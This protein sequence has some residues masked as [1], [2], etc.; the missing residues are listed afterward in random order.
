MANTPKSILTAVLL[1]AFLQTTCAQQLPVKILFV[2]NSITSFNNMPNIF[3]Q[4]A[5][6]K[7]HTVSIHTLVF[8]GMRLNNYLGEVQVGET[9]FVSVLDTIATGN[10]NFVIIQDGLLEPVK[11]FEKIELFYN[12]VLKFDSICK[13]H[14]SRLI[15]F[16][17]YPI[18][19]FPKIY[20]GRSLVSNEMGCTE[21]F[22]DE[23][24]L[25][26]SIKDIFNQFNELNII[27]APIGEAFVTARAKHRR[28]RLYADDED[29]H[30]SAFGSYLMACVY[31]RIC[32]SEKLESKTCLPIK[33]KEALVAQKIANEIIIKN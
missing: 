8:D 24:Q 5:L 4:L 20:C 23:K 19:V 25:L 28:I 1:L 2:G 13:K 6:E 16:K 18:P 21:E 31:Y 32:F 29:F 3:T 12:S 11:P 17:P 10:F 9:R 26:G 14:A 15:I 33:C 7:K 22:L 27:V 30:P